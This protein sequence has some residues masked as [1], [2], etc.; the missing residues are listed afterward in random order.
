MGARWGLLGC[1]WLW[2]GAAGAA[3]GGVPWAQLEWTP[4]RPDAPMLGPDRLAGGPDGQIAVWNPASGWLD[5]YDSLDAWTSGELRSS[6]RLG[7]VDDLVWGAGGLVVLDASART[8]SLL[9]PDGQRLDRASLPE[10]V[11]PGSGLSMEGDALYAVDAFGNRHGLA[12]IKGGQIGAWDGPRVSAPQVS[13]RRRADDH[14]LQVGGR[15]IPVADALAVSGRA[16]VGGGRTW[17][18]IERVVSDAPLSVERQ[19]LC[20][21]TG[22]R[23]DLGP[24]ER[25]YAPSSDLS[26]NGRGQLLWLSPR[27][28]GAHIVEVDP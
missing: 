6:A 1:V 23:V 7:A 13:V 14:A 22:R 19:A 18:I 10:L 15:L 26:V 12:R 11:P 27:P 24:G 9:G 5:T 8:V 28:D 4:A 2:S 3:D 25:S 21:E 20:L 16:L 17:L